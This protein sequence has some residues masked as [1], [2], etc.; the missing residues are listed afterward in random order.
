MKLIS[1]QINPHFTFIDSLHALSSLIIGKDNNTLNSNFEQ[2][3]SSKNIL[4]TNTARSSLGL[5]CDTVRPDP[6]KKIAI[7]AFIC[8]VVATPFLARGYEIEWIET[9]SNGLI[10]VKDFEAKAANV[11]MVVVPHIFGQAA[12]LE[13][14]SEVAKRF[15]IFVIEDGAHLI[16]Q[17]LPGF[18]MIADA[19][20]LS[21]G[22]EK[23]ISCV[24]GGALIWPEKSP[25]HDAFEA[26]KSKIPKPSPHWVIR[27]ALQPFI[28]SISLPWWRKGGKVIPWLALKFK[29]LPLAVTTKEKKGIEDIPVASLGLTQKRILNRQLRFFDTRTIH[30]QAMALTWEDLLSAFFEDRTIVIPPLA[31]RSI[32]KTNS[33]LEKEEFLYTLKKSKA[34]CYLNDWDGVPISPSGITYKKFGYRPGQCPKAEYYALTYITFPTNIRTNKRD[35]KAFAKYLAP[36]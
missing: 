27:H 7:P 10:D 1:N 25:Y 16:R 33:P 17:F 31:F 26:L 9:D 5:I 11:S 20:I 36:A 15:D 30:A 8:A 29:I 24:S 21:F 22:R 19:Q 23:V 2:Y 28:F 6:S 34:P 12:P 14:I 32:L 3:F 18:K 13:A 35:I 4:F